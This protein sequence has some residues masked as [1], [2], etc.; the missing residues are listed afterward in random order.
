MNRISRSASLADR[1]A[2]RASVAYKGSWIRR[3]RTYLR[4]QSVAGADA[5]FKELLGG[6]QVGQS[7]A[8]QISTQIAALPGARLESWMA[9]SCTGGYPLSPIASSQTPKRDVPAG[10]FF[11]LTIAL[12]LEQG[13]WVGAAPFIAGGPSERH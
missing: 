10:Y 12:S 4:N 6:M 3:T 7:L 2:V 8:E 9:E 11:V 1:F 5:W 13:P